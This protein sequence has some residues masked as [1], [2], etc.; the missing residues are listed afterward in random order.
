[1]AYNHNNEKYK[2]ALGGLP[3]AARHFSQPAIEL[4]RGRGRSMGSHKFY[5]HP[6]LRN[7][8]DMERLG[9]AILELAVRSTD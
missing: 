9:R 7:P 6:I 4:R 8:P 1:M 5:L 3:F 2:S